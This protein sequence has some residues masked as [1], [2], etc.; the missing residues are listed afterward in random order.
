MRLPAFVSTLKFR[1]VA[2]VVATGVLSAWGTANLLLGVTQAE[3]TRVLL[4]NERDDRERTA[5]LLA[6]KVHTLR[7]ALIEVARHSRGDAWRDARSMEQYLM[8][9]AALNPL[10]ETVCAARPDG[11]M[12]ARVERGVPQR[13]LP[14]IGDRE[15][16][17][18]A[19]R[20]KQPVLSDPVMGRVKKIPLLIVAVPMLDGV[21]AIPQGMMIGV[22]AL[23]AT[24]LFAEVGDKRHADAAIDLVIDRHGKILAHPQRERL[25]GD[26]ADEPGLHDL[27]TE[28]L[29]DGSPIDVDSRALLSQGHLVSVAGIPTTDWLHLRVTP[30][31]VALHPLA[32]ARQQAWT[33]AAVAG[34][35]SALLAGALAWLLVRPI[36]RL[37]E[38]A[39]RMLDIEASD[40]APWP[41]DHGEVGAM[42]HAFREL[43]EQRQQRQARMGDLV[44]QLEAVL[45]NAEVGIAL[46]RDGR[47]EMVSRRVCQMFRCTREQMVG[48]DTR[49]IYASD[50]AFDELKSRA[51]P[52]FM[53]LG[54]FEGEHELMRRDGEAF[55]ARMR[56]RAVVPGDLSRGTIWVLDDITQARAHREQLT[57]AATHDALT[58]LANR[59]AFEALLEQHTAQS[60]HEPFCALFID[61]DRFK[62]VND[63]G[64]HAAGDTMLREVAQHL[65]A[66]LRKSDTLA[67]IGGD[68]FAV[69]LAQCPV[70]QA[71]AIAEK[72]RTAVEDYALSWHGQIF[73]IGASIGLVCVNG[74]HASGGEV[75]RAADAACYA[76]KREGRNRVTALPAEVL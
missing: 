49:M 34:L 46:T 2:I 76:A 75:L 60:S 51:R 31:A 54:V 22:V 53:A 9:Q 58:G 5:G 33:A 74:T 30:E 20:V 70:P 15:Y 66:R 71:H 39:E 8:S 4:A 43:L 68:E 55:W 65:G 67:R 73:R 44:L 35:L 62:V 50:Q 61:L 12:F 26:A 18:R 32:V 47:F 14:Y 63:S 11:A 13:E 42:A 48:Q 57:W 24:S 69:L 72:L 40:A 3:L 38:R 27:I 52:Q 17:K 36:S 41:T 28:W 19:L 10:F 23:N 1:I 16:F 64:G 45:D 7:Q 59:P 25:L 37:R 56:G 21:E 29:S 6:G